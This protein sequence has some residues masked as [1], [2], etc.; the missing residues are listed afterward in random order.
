LPSA[1]SIFFGLHALLLTKAS[2]LAGLVATFRVPVIS[3]SARSSRPGLPGAACARCAD[4][5]GR[6]A[7][8]SGELT[9]S[10]ANRK[11]LMEMR[12]EVCVRF[13]ASS[14]HRS[15]GASCLWPANG[16]TRHTPLPLAQGLLARRLSD[17][18]GQDLPGESLVQ[19]AKECPEGAVLGCLDSR[20]CHCDLRPRD[21]LAVLHPVPDPDSSERRLLFEIGRQLRDEAGRE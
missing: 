20:L 2:S 1:S 8:A 17:S 4:S 5:A 3:T 7:P 14:W 13:T 11:K 18:S 19:P 10:E 21:D 15:P 12:S 16:A 6:V 9:A